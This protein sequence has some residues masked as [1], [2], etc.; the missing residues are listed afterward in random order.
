MLV[1][2]KFAIVGCLR[3]IIFFCVAP[4]VYLCREG[5]STSSGKAE[6]CLHCQQ[7]RHRRAWRRVAASDGDRRGGGTADL[8]S[9]Q[10][11]VSRWQ[12]LLEERRALIR[13]GGQTGTTDWGMEDLCVGEGRVA[14]GGQPRSLAEQ[15]GDE[16]DGEREQRWSPVCGRESGDTT[17]RRRWQP[18]RCA[19]T[20]C[21]GCPAVSGCKAQR[22]ALW[23]PAGVQPG[24]YRCRRKKGNSTRW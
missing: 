8:R 19:S 18:R 9:C 4:S 16:N 2:G 24:R 11:V 14:V 1:N 13:R 17:N 21:A 3:F 10:R 5:V 12:T 22:Q 20:R 7:Q 23:P 15:P 6:A